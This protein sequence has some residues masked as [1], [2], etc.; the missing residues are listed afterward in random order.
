M[1]IEGQGVT[2]HMWKEPRV[3]ISGTTI[4]DICGVS[5]VS[6]TDW[7]RIVSIFPMSLQLLQSTSAL[8]PP[9]IGLH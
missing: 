2:S 1:S 5:M 9:S 7:E 4:V 6:L 8:V 3:E